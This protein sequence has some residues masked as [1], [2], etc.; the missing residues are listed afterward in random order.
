MDMIYLQGLFVIT[1]FDRMTNEGVRG[2]VQTRSV[3]DNIEEE[4]LKR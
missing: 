4:K 3:V 2:I 1:R